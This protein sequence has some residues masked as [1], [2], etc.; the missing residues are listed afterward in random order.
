M[1]NRFVAAW[2]IAGFLVA[3]CS[4]SPSDGIG[5]TNPQSGNGNPGAPSGV[6]V[7]RPNFVPLSNIL[8]FPTD[9][10]FNDSTDGTLNIPAAASLLPVTELN[11][12]DGYSTVAPATVRFS[13]PID[14]ATISPTNVYMFEVDVNDLL[15][16]ATT[17]FRRALVYGTDYTA[18]VAT[19]VDSGGSTL[20]IVPLKPLNS[21]TG[22]TGISTGYLVI[23]TNGLLDVNGNAATPD[24][25]YLAI[26][27]AQTTDPNTTCT[28]ITDP[29]MNGICRL[30]GAQLAIAS[31]VLT[32]AIVPSIVLTFSFSTQ[33]TAD[34]MN[35]V[36]A[37]AQPTPIGV[38]ATGY[39]LSAVNPALPPIADIYVGQLQIP[40]YLDP[41][42]PLRGPGMAHRSQRC[43]AP[44]RRR[45]SRASTRCRSRRRPSASR[46]SR[47]CRMR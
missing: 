12:L 32:P 46:S 35:Y 22:A 15:N 34:S 39:N 25:D 11:A 16:K 41:A 10:Y 2:L 40:Y 13:A 9:L 3:G 28:A 7:F 33:G 19:T 6:G 26:K 14:P 44:H 4:G 8:P 47:P 37:L 21:S 18:R 43:R 5:P 30:T 42:A 24:R 36:A 20:E 17:G 45:T 23:L 31:A 38:V 29:K 27:N 1:S